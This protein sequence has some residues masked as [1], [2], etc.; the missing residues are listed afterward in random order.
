MLNHKIYLALEKKI[1]SKNN[2]FPLFKEDLNEIRKDLKGVIILVVGAAGSIGGQF[3]K[4]L[5]KFDV[6]FKK[7]LL[8]DKNEKSTYR[9]K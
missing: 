2:R 7:L 1:I 4:D 3:V 6:N 8:L 5:I 9:A